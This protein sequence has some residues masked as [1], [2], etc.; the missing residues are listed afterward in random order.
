MR[1]IDASGNAQTLHQDTDFVVDRITEYGRV[2]PLPG[3]F[4]PP[5]LYVAN[6]VEIT[7]T[8]GYDP[9]PA[10]AA[11]THTVSANPPNQQPDSVVVLAVPQVIKTAILIL[12]SHWYANREPVTAGQ[13]GQIPFHVEQLLNAYS[14]IDFAPSR[15]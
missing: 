3:Q 10:A 8:A 11:D 15:G 2:F 6:S 9:N 14:V 13:A 7:F 4:W 1:Y 5:D 12:V